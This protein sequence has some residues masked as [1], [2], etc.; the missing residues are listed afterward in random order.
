MNLFALFKAIQ[1]A[2]VFEMYQQLNKLG[3]CFYDIAINR[4]INI[5]M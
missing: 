3:L 1:N 5:V 2:S 4:S